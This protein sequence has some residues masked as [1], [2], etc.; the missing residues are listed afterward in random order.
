MRMGDD[1]GLGK[2]AF[3]E[4]PHRKM[5]RLYSVAYMMVTTLRK[6]RI[7]GSMRPFKM[8]P[9]PSC[10]MPVLYCGFW[11]AAAPRLRIGVA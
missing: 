7:A 2:V 9:F 6:I 3:G 4:A 10:G 8:L 1:Y 5:N 11:A